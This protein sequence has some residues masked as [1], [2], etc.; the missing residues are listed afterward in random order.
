MGVT[1]LIP[2]TKRERERERERDIH[3]IWLVE[4]SKNL[5]S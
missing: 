4:Y 2:S 5:L 1:E 3:H